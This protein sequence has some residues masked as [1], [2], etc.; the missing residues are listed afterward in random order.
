MKYS[1]KF[2]ALLPALIFSMC[3]LEMSFGV[4]L[5]FRVV[6]WFYFY[7]IF[8]FINI[9]SSKNS[10]LLILK[11]NYKILYFYA[12]SVLIFAFQYFN[13]DQQY[14]ESTN[15]IFN[16]LWWS[17]FG[18]LL[19]MQVRNQTVREELFW[20]Y[21]L[22]I[23]FF[24]CIL[25]ASLGLIKYYNILIGNLY[26]NYFYQDSLIPGSS[27]STDYNVYAL[28]L[29]YG[30]LFSYELKNQFQTLR[31]KIVFYLGNFV[32]ILS[33]LLCGSRR[34]LL[35]VLG[36][37]FLGFFF[38]NIKQLKNQFDIAKFS[39][40]PLIVFFAFGLFWNE[41]VD[42]IENFGIIDSSISRIFTIVDEFS[43]ESDRTSRFEWALNSFDNA[44]FSKQF[45][46]Q[47]FIYLSEMGSSFGNPEDH[48]H[49]FVLGALLYGGFFAVFFI[50]ICLFQMLNNSFAN[51]KLIFLMLILY[52]PFSLTSSNSLFSCRIFPIIVILS[53]V[54]SKT[55]YNS[56]R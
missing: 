19:T 37:L 4:L 10:K 25:S 21:T 31:L 28:G 36:M 29:M 6:W 3:I 41:I 44:S 47:G 8:S 16:I 20:N 9:I 35:Y 30:I 45:F 50:L 52:L 55:K 13:T 2:R 33:S 14:I 49:N 1:H 18:V 38:Q 5:S 7:S 17:T 27:L 42:K 46:G 12:I 34:G 22:R 51:N 56:F 11:Y 23:V 48:P 53:S 40:L 15:D 54:I 39:G 32:I 43:N 26:S 24:G